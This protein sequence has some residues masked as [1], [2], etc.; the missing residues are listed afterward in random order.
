M[1][2]PGGAGGAGLPVRPEWAA[3]RCHLMLPAVTRLQARNKTG[4]K[5]VREHLVNHYLF[6]WGGGHLAQ[7]TCCHLSLSFGTKVGEIDSQCFL[8]GLM[9]LP[10]VWLTLGFAVM[11]DC[12]LNIFLSGVYLKHGS[13]QHLHISYRIIKTDRDC[14]QF[15]RV[16][17]T[18][19]ELICLVF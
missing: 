5:W 2:H 1:C 8:T 14:L 7:C 4:E 12:S 9:G 3:A 15:D 17:L 6:F 19:K 16:L 18:C 13:V 10:E 11:I